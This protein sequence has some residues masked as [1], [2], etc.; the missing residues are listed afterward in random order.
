MLTRQEKILACID[1]AHQLGL[2]IGALNR[3]IVTREMGNI[4]YVDHASS[5]DLKQKYA[6]DPNVD[7]EAIVDVNYVWG[8]QTLPE[9]VG[10]EAP[11]DYVIASHVIEHVPDLIGWLKE[12]HAVL[13]PGGILALAIPDKRYCFDYCRPLTRPDDVIEAYLQHRRKP[14]PR[15]V[16]DHFSSTVSYNGAITWADTIQPEKL[17]N[18]C[19]EEQALSLAK[20]SLETDNYVDVH[21]WVFTPLSLFQLL[22]TLINL[23]LFDFKVETFGDTEGCEFYLSLQ[24]LDV[25]NG[26]DYQSI[27]LKSLP[28]LDFPF[29]GEAPKVDSGQLQAGIY[30]DNDLIL[31]IEKSWSNDHSLGLIGWVLSQAALE[32]ME[33]SVD[34]VSVPINSWQPRPDVV[35]THPSYSNENC[36][37]VVQIPRLAKHQATFSIKTQAGALAKTLSFEG[38]KPLSPQGFAEG[39]NLFNEFIQTVNERQLRVLEIGSRIVSPGSTSKKLLFPD[40]ASY[41]GFDYYPDQNTDVVGDA[42]QLSSYFDGKRFDAIFSL[43]V[44]EHLAMPWLVAKEIN[45]LLEIGGITL[46]MTHNTWPIHEQPWDF[47]RFSDEALKV[48][49]SRAL[50]FEI[51][52]VG[53]FEPARIYLDQLVSGMEILP[54]L[55][56]FGGV[57]ILARKIADINLEK[58]N[59][60]VTVQEIL[61]TESHYPPSQTQICQPDQE[62]SSSPDSTSV[63]PKTQLQKSQATVQRLRKKV[64]L[65]EEKLQGCEAEIAAMQSS[66]FWQLRSGWMRLKQFLKV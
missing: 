49:F 18:F 42:H 33:I 35:L 27:Q 9:L 48:L 3:P 12:I 36:G 62:R 57:C 15:Q 14:S 58:F 53:Y 40:A 46:H 10:S 44:F 2:E 38:S 13:K 34:G 55:P 1:P 17:V 22:R 25:K 4:R 61:D 56:A 64:H 30:R 7:I 23:S 37:F 47:W 51:L 63:S 41:T 50:G 21:C 28:P 39:G 29:K 43:S 11:F 59:W 8:A 19:T 45:Q 26:N 16:F 6:T 5:E 31:A 32:S 24:A 52:K 65:L 66:K 20:Y 60:N 54:T